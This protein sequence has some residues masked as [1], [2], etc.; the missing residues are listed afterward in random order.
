MRQHSLVDAAVEPAAARIALPG[1]AAVV[2]G[3]L[4]TMVVAAVGAL[5]AYL[6]I[7][8]FDAGLFSVSGIA[9]P[10]LQALVV[11]SIRVPIRRSSWL[12]RLL[13]RARDTITT[14]HAFVDA[15]V[16]WTPAI[17]DAAFALAATRLL[18]KG[19][20]FV[21]NVIYPPFAPRGFAMPFESAK[22]AE[23]FAAWD[24]GWYFDIAQRGYYFRPDGQSS[25]AFF[26][27][28]P[29]LMRALAWPVGGRERD[30]WVSGIVL[31]YACFF[32]ALVILH[33]L[34]E[35]MTGQR[36]AARR[37]ILYLAVFPFSF[38]FSRVY[39]ESLFLFV[40]V[41]A[42]AGAGA[43]RWT[44]A[45]GFGA[46]ATLTRPNGML[47]GIPLALMALQ[48]LGGWRDI[49]RRAVPLAAI[50]AALGLYC[51]FLYRL[52]GDPV[53]WL[54][55]QSEWGYSVGHAPWATVQS[56]I[57]RLEQ[58]GPYTY[59]VTRSDAVY[60]VL[61]A[62]VGLGVLALTPS[63]VGRLGMALGC[64]VLVSI[65]VPLSGNSIE[66]IGRYASTLFPVFMF[67]GATSSRR[68][69]EALLIGGALWLALLVALFVTHHPVY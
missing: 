42:V 11:I 69:H 41:A 34:T 64:Y 59:L 56:L 62:L 20:G 35:R 39:A 6:A 9:K 26:P 16:P 23:T 8:P 10:L 4:D 65:L 58:V 55:A 53:A 2:L 48:G 7:G 38:A 33:R 54:H 12:S 24:S 63:I 43:G 22:F 47:I 29:M 49:V 31:S 30:L 61:H 36:E 67:L 46:L 21:A 5:L 28:Y 44:L 25:V 68:V 66:G 57:E 50:P 52:S 1:V 60:H 27:L 14:A 17:I 3:L 40:S 45:G 19:I 13:G 15:H 18:T 37:T 32:G 51:L